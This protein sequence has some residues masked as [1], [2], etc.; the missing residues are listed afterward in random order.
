[1]VE[2]YSGVDRRSTSGI[3]DEY[4]FFEFASLFYLFSQ[5]KGRGK[6]FQNRLSVQY[7]G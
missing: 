7:V 3:M 4:V 2:D 1:M 6:N 5:F